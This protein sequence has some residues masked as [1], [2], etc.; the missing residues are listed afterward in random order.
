MKA[1]KG[2]IIK[3][4]LLAVG[5]VGFI[6]LAGALA[7]NVLKIFQYTDRKSSKIK[8]SAK[9]AKRSLYNLE[10]RGM[11]AIGQKGEKTIIRLT[12]KGKSRVL[13]YNFEKIK[14][15]TQKRW[16]KK[17]RIIIF[18]IPELHK[19]AR[20]A[21][22]RKLREIG[23]SMFQKSVWIIPYPCEDE[24]DFIK[25]IYGITQHVNLIIAEKIDKESK[26]K[27]IYNL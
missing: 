18:D 2:E 8:Y 15:E 9:Q 23:F 13:K 20:I 26:F 3:D 22:M 27:K 6:I 1:K 21:F 11:V 10:H 24:I 12:K 19:S 25:E 5:A 14:I 17:W 16:D 7:P 4:I